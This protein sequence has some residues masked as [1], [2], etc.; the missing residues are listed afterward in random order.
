[1]IKNIAD[2]LEELKKNGIDLIN[3]E[4]NVEHP[5][6]IGDIFEGLTSELLNKSIFKGFDLKIRTGKIKNNSNELSSQID[7]MLVTGK[8]EKVPF[9]KHYIYH[10]SQVIAVL[11][12]KKTLN[13]QQISNSHNNLKSIIKVS[14]GIDSNGEQYMMRML[15]TSWELLT[16]TELPRREDLDKLPENYQY[17]YHNLLMEAYF[18]LRIVFGYFGYNS[19]YSLREG[20]IK[21]LEDK[22]NADERKGLGVGSLPNLIICNDFSLI[23]SNGM[24]F[25]IPFQNQEFYWPILISSNKKPLLNLLELI[26]TRLSFKFGISSTIFDDDLEID[27]CHKFLDCKLD[28]DSVGNKGWSYSYFYI[29]KENLNK[30]FPIKKWQPAELDQKEFKLINVLCVDDELSLDDEYFINLLKENNCTEDE[31]LNSLIEKR[32]IFKKEKTIK[33]ST[34]QCVTI[35]KNG[36]YYAGD[37][38]NGF[39]TKWAV[40]NK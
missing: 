13:K 9:T 6:M 3:S 35:V 21:M 23:K 20:F 11:E 37:N 15:K 25:A 17:I 34:R 38:F 2:F 12:V 16:N 1:M 36:K 39:M 27:T 28:T 18:P 32:L 8:G 22:I 7:C 5:G 40:E 33:L 26:W 24:P 14:R 10:Y 4:R 29:D 31:I 19:E 30:E